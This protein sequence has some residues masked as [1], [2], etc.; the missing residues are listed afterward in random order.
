MQASGFDQMGELKKYLRE[1]YNEV[2]DRLP[3]D[4][5]EEAAEELADE[6]IHDI[7]EAVADINAGRVYTTEELM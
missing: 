7:E 4:A 1:T 2:I 5:L 6:D 3:R